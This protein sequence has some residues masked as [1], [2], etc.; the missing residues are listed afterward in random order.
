LQLYNTTL[1]AADI[2]KLQPIGG[3]IT[4]QNRNKIIRR[5]ANLLCAQAEI[6]SIYTLAAKSPTDEPSHAPASLPHC[7]HGGA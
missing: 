2:P 4:L 1:V 5:F 3:A 6:P 7:V